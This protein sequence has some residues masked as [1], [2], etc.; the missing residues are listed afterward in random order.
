[1]DNIFWWLSDTITMQS[2]IKWIIDCVFKE[3][4]EE[5]ECCYFNERCIKCINEK[6]YNMKWKMKRKFIKTIKITLE[7]C[8][9]KD[10]FEI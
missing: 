6:Y 3:N 1:M 9:W 5:A 4:I 10:A 7:I 2:N 8:M